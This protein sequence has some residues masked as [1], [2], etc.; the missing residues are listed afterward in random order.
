MIQLYAHL[1]NSMHISDGIDCKPRRA[2]ALSRFTTA[3][4]LYSDNSGYYTILI[5]RVE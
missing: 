2:I 5:I 3:P 4:N 1:K